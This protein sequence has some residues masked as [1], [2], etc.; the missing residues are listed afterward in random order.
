[1]GQITPGL[2]RMAEVNRLHTGGV[3]SRRRPTQ[4]TAAVVVLPVPAVLIKLER[5]A[6]LKP[7]KP[8]LCIEAPARG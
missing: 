8:P 3:P 1:M 4:T 2:D 5:A 6:A 7:P